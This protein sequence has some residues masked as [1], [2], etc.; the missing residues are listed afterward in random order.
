MWLDPGKFK[1]ICEFCSSQESNMQKL[2]VRGH[3]YQ[4]GPEDRGQVHFQ[5]QPYD[6]DA[7]CC[8]HLIRQ[9]EGVRRPIHFHLDPQGFIE[10]G[11]SFLRPILK[12]KSFDLRALGDLIEFR[13]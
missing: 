9:S 3:I 12:E 5:C 13:S 11:S 2:E 10:A 8:A 7:E 6:K 1:P 4:M